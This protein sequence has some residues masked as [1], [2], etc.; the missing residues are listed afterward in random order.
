MLF[1]GRKLGSRT[2][3]RRRLAASGGPVEVIRPVARLKRA[4]DWGTRLVAVTLIVAC[5]LGAVG[6]YALLDFAETQLRTANLAVDL[7]D[8]VAQLGGISDQLVVPRPVSGAVMNEAI[9]LESSVRDRLAQLRKSGSEPTQVGALGRL[10][11]VYLS[12]FD[13]ERAA[14]LAGH[15]ERAAALAVT[16]DG[17]FAKLTPPALSIVRELRRDALRADSQIRKVV[18]GLILLL[19]TSVVALLLW[20]ARRGRRRA[21]SAASDS[22][23]SRFETLVERSS[24]LIAVIGSDGCI[25]Y[26]SPSITNALGGS[27]ADYV[28]AG[29][30]AFAAAGGPTADAED[31]AVFDRV[32]SSPGRSAAFE[33]TLI[34]RNGH[35]RHYEAV[36]TNLL[37]E[38]T[39]K[40]V[41]LNSRDI[42]ERAQFERELRDR[43]ESFRMLF[44]D[45]PYPMWVFDNDTQRF[46]R[47]NDAA[48]HQ[49]GYSQEEFA[50]MTI[51]D[52]RPPEGRAELVGHLGQRGTAPIGP[53]AVW[54]HQ[55]K[56]G[57]RLDVEVRAHQLTFDARDATLVLAQDVTERQRL[58]AALEHRAFHDP[59][60]ELPNR[61]LF[62][63]R[64]QHALDAALRTD[65]ELCVLFLDLDGFKTV[66]DTLGHAAGDE[67]LE[68]VARRMQTCLRSGDTIARM[69]GDEFAI[70]LE[71]TSP[72]EPGLLASR[73]LDSV[74][75][76]FTVHGQEIFLTVS[77]GITGPQQFADELPTRVQLLRDADLAMYDAKD[78]GRDRYAFFAPHMRTRT[79]QRLILQT[80][81]QHALAR[82]QLRV[83]Y[84]PIVQLD[85]LEIVGF[86]ALLRWNHPERGL[87]S[88]SK[89]VPLAEETG[90]IVP[91]GRWVLREACRQV[92]RWRRTFDGYRQLGIAVNVSGRQL[93]GPPFV[94]DVRDA[95]E[96]AGLDPKAVTLE[97]TESVL[98]TNA[99]AI[100]KQLQELKD[101]GVR[102][103]ID[104]FGTGYSSLS[105]LSR[106]PLDIMKIDKSFLVGT[107][108]STNRQAMLRSIVD[109]AH[110]LH[111]ST[112]GEGIETTV[113]L[114]RL[115]TSGCDLGQGFLFNR[116]LTA[117]QASHRLAAER[118]PAHGA[119]RE[120]MWD[121]TQVE[122][123]Y[124]TMGRSENPSRYVGATRESGPE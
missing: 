105:Y 99:D 10:I 118:I 47:V 92:A 50:E 117:D 37:E 114:E 4:A 26:V 72:G 34:D 79:A 68:R 83:Y 31:S 90:L 85:S 12:M 32:L 116:P 1:L 49:Y 112:L 63:D 69:G 78:T 77:I 61:A 120:G 76:P 71:N 43:E 94:V 91:I 8:G 89:F 59:L 103:A 123:A 66:N 107:H 74:R 5:L 98:L 110:S 22:S 19:V 106:F 67:L 113:E 60:T 48:C 97:I 3:G 55:T 20:W 36:A 30:D 73:L 15:H 80:D 100:A 64:V 54:C 13:H 16:E 108:D 102:L 75:E 40:G 70:L 35:E 51:F 84:Q 86:E 29:W 96:R 23:L 44:D 111:L 41:V 115:R 21:T 25:A 17:Q 93:Q 53:A 2:I 28:G 119:A 101:C 11:D 95:V 18:V 39:I 57:S 109:M 62:R 124:M 121:A 42:T 104:D 122:D 82:D 88:P 7:Q 9:T 65:G 56:D 81:L 87:I 52:L 46:L 38:P 14:V 27:S 33:Y 6:A 24:D 58:E 45:N